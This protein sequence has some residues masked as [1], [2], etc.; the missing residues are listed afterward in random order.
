[1]TKRVLEFNC[2]DPKSNQQTASKVD[3]VVNINNTNQSAP[4]KRKISAQK[5]KQEE[6]SDDIQVFNENDSGD[7]DVRDIEST[8]DAEVKNLHVKVPVNRDVAPVPSNSDRFYVTARNPPVLREEI[9]NSSVV[10]D[11]L[12][13]ILSD[14]LIHN[15]AQLIANIIDRSG[16][17]IL[18]ATDFTRLLSTILSAN[19]KQVKPGDIKLKYNEDIETTCFKV[20]ISPFKH[21]VSIQVGD[22]DLK[23]HQYEAYNALTNDF[24]I[25][26][27]M[28]Y[29]LDEVIRL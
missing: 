6:L 25:S 4:P 20:K 15:D 10:K 27:E 21:V 23:L 17:I 14:L 16:K 28:I 19:G 8:D 9:L 12:I 29:I 24:N 5:S 11:T 22:Q 13:E 7:K 2:G 3:M 26:S 18:K 1:M